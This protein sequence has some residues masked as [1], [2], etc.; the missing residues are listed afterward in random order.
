MHGQIIL[1]IEICA[2]S[3][4][5][6]HASPML[7]MPVNGV[8]YCCLLNVESGFIDLQFPNFLLKFVIWC[9]IF[10]AFISHIDNA[11]F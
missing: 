11:Y 7:V 9:D 2:I 3:Q 8:S 10:P 6:T 5:Q 4:S 1:P